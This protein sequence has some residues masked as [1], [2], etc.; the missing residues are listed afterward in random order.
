MF[1]CTHAGS[2]AAQDGAQALK[3][4]AFLEGCL[5]SAAYT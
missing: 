5:G 2:P 4:R 1:V 3:I